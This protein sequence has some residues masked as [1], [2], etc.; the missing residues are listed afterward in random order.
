MGRTKKQH[1]ISNSILDNFFKANKI[2]EYN[3]KSNRDYDCSTS[4]SMCCSDVYESDLFE[5]NKLEDAFAKNY[6]G[7]FSNALCEID[8]LLEEN[9]I[10][11]AINVLKHNFYYYTISYYKSLAS[12][13][14]LSRNDNQKLEKN[15]STIRMFKLITNSEYLNQM[16]R[17]Y[18]NC[19]N[20][21]IIKSCNSN[22]VLCDQFISTASNHFNGLFSNMSNRDIGVKGSI[23]LFP[24]SIDYYFLLYDKTMPPLNSISSNTINALTELET[25]KINNI[26]YNNA[27]EKVC[28]IKNQK[29]EFH[30]VNSYGDESIYIVN[31]NLDSRGFKKKK[32]VF[33]SEKEQDLYKMFTEF[34]WCK[35]KKLGKN[36]ECFCGSGKKFKKC[37][38]DKVEKCKLIMSNIQNKSIVEKSLIDI[39]LGL[40]KYIEI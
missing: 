9:Q 39:R 23:I 27:T 14:R 19:Y 36:E 13:I 40:E 30:N 12:L 22:F 37:C 16:S 38:Y 24:V 20:I 34:K 4:N 25:D 26:I 8:T 6:D 21:Y 2:H 3:L 28:T 7:P 5:D 35:Y 31:S 10:E 15:S 11:E 33:Y 1:Y 18:T 29:Y 32:E 17:I